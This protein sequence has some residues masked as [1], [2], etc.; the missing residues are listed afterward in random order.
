MLRLLLTTIA[1]LMYS[2]LRSPLTDPLGVGGSEGAG[3]RG[4]VLNESEGLRDRGKPL[5]G[6]LALLHTGCTGQDIDLDTV[7]VC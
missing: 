2:P 7:V 5:D 1:S 3:L 4:K 6:G